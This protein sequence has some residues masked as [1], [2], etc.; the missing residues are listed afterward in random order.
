[1]PAQTFKKTKF[2]T[3]KA[4]IALMVL[5]TLVALSLLSNVRAQQSD[6]VEIVEELQLDQAALD[7]IL[8]PIALYPD[9][10]LSQIL[11]ASTYPLEVV[12]ATRWR[13]A[14]SDLDED[15]VL[16][17]IED[18]TWDPS[19]KALAPFEDLLVRISEDLEW[20]QSLGNAFLQNEEQVLASVQNL[21]QK[22]YEN[23]SIADNEYYEVIEEDD[24]IIIESTQ[25]EI[26]YVPYYDTRVVYG[27]WWWYDYQPVYWD[28]PRHYVHLHGGFYWNSGFYVRPSIF[29][30]GFHWGT[31]HLVVNHYYYNNP[32]RYDSR[33][34]N[35]HISS[36]SH[37][38]HNPEHRHGVRYPDKVVRSYTSSNNSSG[39]RTIQGAQVTTSNNQYIV[40]PSSARSVQQQ[41]SVEMVQR[42]LNESKQGVRSVGSV[43]TRQSPKWTNNST[44]RTTTVKSTNSSSSNRSGVKTVN[45]STTTSVVRPTSTSRGSISQSTNSARQQSVVTPKSYGSGSAYNRASSSST[46]SN[47]VPSS[48][49][50]PSFKGSSSSSAQKSSQQPTVKTVNRSKAYNRR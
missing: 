7:Q 22:A 39:S 2:D 29:Y 42:K 1:M 4:F 11:V 25:R 27:P 35:I 3:Q 33:D 12:Q 44:N 34:R 28:R 21:R 17:A 19:V 50:T 43:E 14:N 46:R 48:S 5:F 9:A 23:G 36:Y 49:G 20:L 6:G 37:W 38:T 41:S 47:S 45:P 30:G 31:R 26:I 8:A 15:Q 16:A 24:N 40:K 13:Q 32:R 18:K 10:L